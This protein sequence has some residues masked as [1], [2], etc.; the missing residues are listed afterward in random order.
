MVRDDPVFSSHPEF[1][2]W[3]FTFNPFGIASGMSI[4]CK[5][6]SMQGFC[7]NH[8]SRVLELALTSCVFMLIIKDLKQYSLVVQQLYNKQYRFQILQNDS[9]QYLFLSGVGTNCLELLINNQQQFS[10]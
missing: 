8:S 2:G 4:D 10:L 5:T 1:S 9:S 6:N 3:L 7:N